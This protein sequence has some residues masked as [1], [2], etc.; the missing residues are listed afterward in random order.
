MSLCLKIILLLY[1]WTLYDWKQ[2]NELPIKS[3][4][5]ALNT[6]VLRLIYSLELRQ[7][8]KEDEDEDGNL[9]QSN[10]PW[11]VK[12]DISRKGRQC[13]HQLKY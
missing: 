2:I 5:R 10:Q 6:D 11:L 4:V 12:Q 9:R 1:G 7:T 8:V 13:D 3:A